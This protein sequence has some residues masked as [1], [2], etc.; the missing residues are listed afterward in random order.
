MLP[1]TVKATLL[2]WDGSFVGK[3][4]KEVWKAGPLCIFWTVWKTRNK[5]AFKDD[6]LSV[7]RLKSSFIFFLWSKTKLFIKDGPSTLV[8]FIKDAILASLFNIVFSLLLIK[9]YIYIYIHTLEVCELTIK[10]SRKKM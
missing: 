8:G 3:K 10:I 5:I 2:G 7:Q 9:I 1:T 6:V 4:K